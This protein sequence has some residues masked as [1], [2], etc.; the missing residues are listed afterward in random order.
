MRAGIFN[1]AAR[2]EARASPGPPAHV[3]LARLGPLW[4]RPLRPR[5]HARRPPHVGS[6]V[7]KSHKRL[8]SERFSLSGKSHEGTF[9]LRRRNKD[10]FHAIKQKKSFFNLFDCKAELTRDGALLPLGKTVIA[11]QNGQQMLAN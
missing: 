7:S 9:Q 3:G 4:P 2:A 8:A 5:A 1:E 11:Q 10:K 6:D